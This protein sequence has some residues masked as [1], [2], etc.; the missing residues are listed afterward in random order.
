VLTRSTFYLSIPDICCLP[1]MGKQQKILAVCRCMHTNPLRAQY[2]MSGCDKAHVQL[3]TKEVHNAWRPSASQVAIRRLTLEAQAAI[4][5]ADAE[6][7]MALTASVVSEVEIKEEIAP[8]PMARMMRVAAPPHKLAEAKAAE[9]AL[10]PASTSQ[11]LTSPAG[12][13][14]IPASYS[15]STVFHGKHF[16]FTG[17]DSVSCAVARPPNPNNDEQASKQESGSELKTERQLADRRKNQRRIDRC[18]ERYE[19]LTEL[20]RRYRA[21]RQFSGIKKRTG[22]VT[23]VK[24]KAMKRS[25]RQGCDRGGAN[26]LDFADDDGI[27]GLGGCGVQNTGAQ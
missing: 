18:A 27:K 17:T 14:A 15:Y 20:E 23:G 7:T 10:T 2:G 3:R 16:H 6:R 9:R 25:V 4:A 13:C 5:V 1:A 19:G 21:D 22:Q 11:P 26:R 12:P 24:G 8:M